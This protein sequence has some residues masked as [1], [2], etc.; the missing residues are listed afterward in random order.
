[1]CD[2]QEAFFRDGLDALPA[3]SWPAAASS[4]AELPLGQAAFDL[5]RPVKV[6]LWKG[7]TPQQRAQYA[8]TCQSLQK[9]KEKAPRSQQLGAIAAAWDSINVLRHGERIALP[10][11]A[12][13]SKEKEKEQV[14]PN[15]W[16]TVG[17]IRTATC[18]IGS[19]CRRDGL[20]QTHR[21]LDAIMSV[22]QTC[23]SLLSR[24]V[25]QGLSSV[26]ALVVHRHHDAT[27]WKVHFGSMTSSIAQF[28]RYQVKGIDGK[29][30]LRPLADWQ[31]LTRKMLPSFGIVE[32]FAQ[33]IRVCFKPDLAS[34]WQERD[35]VARPVLLANT[36]ASC[37]YAA[38]ERSFATFSCDRLNA[39]A[40]KMGIFIICCERPDNAKSN[41]RKMAQTSDALNE[42]VL[43]VPGIC[44]S[45]TLQ[46]CI[47]HTNNEKKTTGDVYAVQL[48]VQ[49]ISH[50]AKLLRALRD[51][52]DCNLRVVNGVLNLPD[53]AAQAH[54]RAILSRTVGF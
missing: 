26:A 53:A 44:M 50:Q 29:W 10:G 8:R 43:Y 23:T 41:R 28:A 47:E 49:V 2:S 54:T 30:H 38:L 13:N 22:A 37:L 45:H 20:G 27:P 1:M 48:V 16:T 52:L 7:S 4:A 32:L 35:V 31:K 51:V 6:R 40:L 19:R 5:D 9:E 15:K 18:N 3:E 33:D 34:S 24:A 17:L 46:R 42:K 25:E 12:S 14:H 21:T 11:G 36:G 39:L